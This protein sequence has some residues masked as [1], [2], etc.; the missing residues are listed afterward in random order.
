VATARPGVGVVVVVTVR[1]AVGGTVSVGELVGDGVCVAVGV[2]VAVAG[3]VAVVAVVGGGVVVAVRVGVEVSAT[4]AAALRSDRSTPTV[5]STALASTSC[6]TITTTR[7]RALYT[8]G[9]EDASL[10]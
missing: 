1:V 9:T 6:S 7:A 2:A 4:A 3:A 8:E 5:L 10:S